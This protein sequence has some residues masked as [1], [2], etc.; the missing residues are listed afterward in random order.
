MAAYL[1]NVIEHVERGSNGIYIRTSKPEQVALYCRVSTGDQDCARRERHLRAFAERASYK[2]VAVHKETASG[3]K[4]DRELRGEVLQLAREKKIQNVLVTELSRWGRSLVDLMA[5]LNGL[6]AY[7][8]SVIAQTGLRFDLA[9]PQGKMK[10][11]VFGSLAEFERDLLK[12]R[13]KSG[14]AC[15]R[16][17]RK[18]IGREIGQ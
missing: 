7:N 12:E 14:I 9:T 15:A 11:G 10:A 8:F 1:S 2:V 3:V 16:A 5:T 17:K 6:A 13:I 18:K 4:N